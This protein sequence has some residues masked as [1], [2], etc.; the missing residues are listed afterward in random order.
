V[1]EQHPV[2]DGLRLGKPPLHS[3]FECFFVAFE[4]I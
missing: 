1:W 4:T 3:W 2:R